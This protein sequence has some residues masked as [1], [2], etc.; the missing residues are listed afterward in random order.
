MNPTFRKRIRR[1][2][3]VGMIALTAGAIAF[4][5]LPSFEFQ[6]PVREPQAAP[7]LGDHYLLLVN[8]AIAFQMD[9]SKFR[10]FDKSSYD[11]LAVA[12]LHAYDTSAVPSVPAMAAKIAEWKKFTHKDIW[13]WVYTNRMIGTSAEENNS[14]A[15]VPY[16]K[17]IQGMDLDDK[18]GALT[19]FYQIWR[20]SLGAARDTKAP[21]VVLDIEFYN[22]YKLYNIGELARV[23]GKKPKEV[24]DSLRQIGAKMA[25]IAANEYPNATLWLL[26]TGLTH[27][28]HTNFENTP[29]YASTT[30]IAI[31]L[32]D[33]IAKSHLPLKLLAGGEGSIGYCH[34]NVAEFQ[35]TIQKREA[36]LKEPLQK[37]KEFFSLAGTMTLWSDKKSKTGWVN[38]GKCKN[39][40]AATV[41][42]LEPYL[43]LLLRSYRYNWIYGSGDGNYLAFAPESAARFDRVIAKAKAGAYSKY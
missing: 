24:A 12:F 20:N 22:Y 1:L 2:Q 35:A 42:D 33:E 16:F 4:A 30:Y 39:S 14:H 18:N 36:D 9:E 43:E 7:Q 34:D 3:L 23:T 40:E 37:Y 19:D 41:E 38:E 5:K 21:G 15:D 32:M 13:P 8:T 17:R 26:I 31:G 25:N 11:G 6:A 29:Y 10:Q 27:A 28:G